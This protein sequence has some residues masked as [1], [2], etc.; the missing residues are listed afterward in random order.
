MK[1][2]NVLT[3]AVSITNGRAIMD[4]FGDY[5]QLSKGSSETGYV[6]SCVNTMGNYIAGSKLRLYQKVKGS[7]REIENHPFLDLWESPNNFQVSWELKYF[8]GL[9]LATKGNYYLL[10]LNGISSGKPRELVIL[11]PMRVK[12]VSSSSEW[13]SYYEYDMGNKKIKLSREEVIHIRYPFGGSTIEGKAIIESIADIID[14]DRYQQE[15][16]KKFYKEGG[17]LGLTFS[18]TGTLT[19]SAFDRAVRQLKEKYSGSENAFKV[20]VFEQ[21]LQPIKAAYSIKDM[22]LT[23]QRKLTQEEV[24]TAFRMPKLLLGGSA[25]GYTKASSE[26]AEYTYA[27]T[28]VDPLLTYIGQVLTRHVRQLYKD[29]KLVVKHDSVAPKDVERKLTYY[30]DMVGIG[31]LTI[32]EVRIEEDYDEF[33]YELAKVPILNVG[34]AA[35]NIATQEQIGAVPNN[36]IQPDMPDDSDEPDEK[37]FTKEYDLYWKQYDRRFRK[38]L[39]QF[40]KTLNKFFSDQEKRLLDKLNQKATFDLEGFFSSGEL[41]ILMNMMENAYVRFLERGMNFGGLVN[42]NAP[43]IKQGLIDLLSKAEGINETTK[44]TLSKR[45]QDA[46][47]TELKSVIKNSFKDFKEGRTDVIAETTIGGGFNLGLLTS[48]QLQGYKKKMWISQKDAVVRDD[49]FLADGQVVGINEP[50]NVGGEALQYPTDPNGS[51]EQ[52]INCRCVLLGIKE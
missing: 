42:L 14:V 1:L 26:S 43:Q 41:Q 47:D 6:A 37:S 9:Y 46:D 10:I 12:P 29:N 13:I 25:E 20:A 52:T 34:G 19:N 7:L 3:K 31:A 33:T 39:T 49:H 11:D 48:Y 24:M 5:W 30:K 18:T 22:E 51:P 15:L 36:V 45:I 32:N 17:F 40:K 4:T 50:F 35:I 44:K 2:L 27:Q 28:F 21:G 38:E 8:M 16:T 23:T